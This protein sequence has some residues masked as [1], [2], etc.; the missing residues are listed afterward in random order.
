VFEKAMAEILSKK[1]VFSTPWFSIAA[2]TIAGYQDPFYAL[3]C[4]DYVAVCAVTVDGKVLLVRQY[5]P[6]VESETLEFVCGHVE[7]GERPEEAARR[8]L[9]EEA[10]FEAP[11]LELLQTL[12]SDTGRLTNRLW[13][14]FAPG[15]VPSPIPASEEGLTLVPCPVAELLVQA[16]AQGRLNQAFSM[17]LLFLLCRQGKL[18]LAFPKA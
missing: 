2:K 16:G 4:L 9:R 18:G 11:T 12:V 5:R 7:A 13:C 3:E 6:A 14:F 15:A 10:G 17:A 1:V 8:E